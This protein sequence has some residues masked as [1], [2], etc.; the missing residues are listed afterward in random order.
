[1]D[2]SLM[3]D[4]VVIAGIATWL[5]QK[6][7]AWSGL[8]AVQQGAMKAVRVFASIVALLSASGILVTTNWV[9]AEGTFSLAITGISAGNITLFQIGRAHV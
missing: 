5:I 4:Q 8:P 1:M 2:N 9:G 7:K 3:L 6:A